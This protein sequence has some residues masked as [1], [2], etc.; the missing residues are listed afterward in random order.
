MQRSLM[1][2]RQTKAYLKVSRATLYRLLQ[3]DKI[4]GSKVGGQWRFRRE[5][6][7]EW[8]KE[9]EG[10]KGIRARRRTVVHR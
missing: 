2:F 4:P 3:T 8:L 6:L 1:D 5:R 7:D 9:Q 10:K